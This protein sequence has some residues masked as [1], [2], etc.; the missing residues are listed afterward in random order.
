M[1]VSKAADGR[2]CEMRMKAENNVFE[3]LFAFHA[4]RAADE[5]RCT[6]FTNESHYIASSSRSSTFHGVHK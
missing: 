3:C 5:I 2:D 6:E 4:S 1:D